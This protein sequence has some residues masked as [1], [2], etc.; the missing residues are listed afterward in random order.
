MG[1]KDK[2]AQDLGRILLQQ[3]PD[4]EKVAQG[5]GHLFI[6]DGDKAV[7]DPG[8]DK[9]LAARPLTLGNFVFMMG[10][11]KV[12]AA[13]MDIKGV[14]QIFFGHGR[15][16]DMPA[17]ATRSPWTV[18]GGF[19]RLTALPEDKIHG[20]FLLVAHGNTGTGHHIRQITAGKGAIV[21]K[22]FHPVVDIAILL[23]GQPLSIKV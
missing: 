10:E 22:P 11:D 7:M 1:R 8:V 19:A 3:L 13:A 20:V 16:F 4:G 15:A 23:I 14:A 5:L 17:G 21:G 2:E 6:L 9:G 12:L 18:P